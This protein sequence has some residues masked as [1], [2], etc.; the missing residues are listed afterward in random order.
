MKEKMN[1]RQCDFHK[2]LDDRCPKDGIYG[3]SNWPIGKEY[4]GI[5][6]FIR[7]SRWCEDHRHEGDILLK[8]TK[9]G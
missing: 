5:D 1:L 2:F 6:N 4:P 8:E 9:N 7:N 3:Q